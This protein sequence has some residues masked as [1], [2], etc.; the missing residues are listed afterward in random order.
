MAADD[1]FQKYED[2]VIQ[3]KGSDASIA[4]CRFFQVL[5]TDK[6]M[7][8]T[9][10]LYENEG[11]G[12]SRIRQRIQRTSSIVVVC[13]LF[14]LHSAA[15]GSEKQV[16][17]DAGELDPQRVAFTASNTLFAVMHEMGHAAITEFE[18]PI[19]GGHE[20]AADALA[21]VVFIQARESLPE[22]E[23]PFFR[24]LAAAIVSQKLVWETGLE[25]EQLETFFW[26][27]H[28]L[29]I[30][31]YHDSLCLLYGSDP[32]RL[33]FLPEMTGMP[34]FRSWDCDEEFEEALRS[35]R[36]LMDLALRNHPDRVAKDH[37][38]PISYAEIA[39][40]VTSQLLEEMDREF[41][42]SVLDALQA[43]IV[44]PRNMTIE[45]RSCEYPNAFWDPDENLM[46]T[47]YELIKMFYD[48][49]EDLDIPELIEK[50]ESYTQP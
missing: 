6:L 14:A 30:Q 47:C 37:D 22:S 41:L 20:Q 8:M 7:N 21:T 33:W 34:D 24:A 36:Q 38:F 5:I 43:S 29:S 15:M 48:L 11:S 35:A 26:A 27:A 18:L 50:V 49:S 3:R 10:N 46:T 45:F 40:P 2:F 17:T 9:T 32:G 1:P 13:L 39:D 25:R 23:F 4:A 16:T 19:L 28:K 31:R 42:P 12:L 44:I